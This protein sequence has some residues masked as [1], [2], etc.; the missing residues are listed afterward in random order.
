MS[1]SDPERIVTT[2]D[3]TADDYARYAAAVER[4]GR[5]WTTFN[6]FAASFFC[7]IPVALWFRALAA[8]ILNNSEAI[9]TAGRFSLYAF[10]LGVIATL[11]SAYIVQHIKRKRYYKTAVWTRDTWTTVLDRSG[12]SMSSNGSEWKTPWAALQRCTREHE[13]LLVWLGLASA[14]S[15]PCRSFASKEACDQAIAF[16]RARLAEARANPA[17]ARAEI[18]QPES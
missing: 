13:L 16:I 2:Y 9:E 14:V 18:A 8:Q 3:F 12:I 5:S 15:I 7:A 17:T 6:I 1:D 4:R 10:V 11:I